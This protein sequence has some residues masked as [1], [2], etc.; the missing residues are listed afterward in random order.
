MGGI[1]AE[2]D[3]E[4]AATDSY[5]QLQKKCEATYTKYKAVAKKKTTAKTDSKTASA[6][7]RTGASKTQSLQRINRLASTAGDPHEGGTTATVAF[8]KGDSLSVACA[9][10]SR[11]VLGS[12]VSNSITAT[13]L[14]IDHNLTNRTNWSAAENERY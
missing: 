3:F 2:L 10:D 9:G 12:V 4:R 5:V 6:M 11:A 13:D 14:T 1:H 8:I 7:S